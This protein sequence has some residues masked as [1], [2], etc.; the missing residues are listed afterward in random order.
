MEHLSDPA[1]P[2]IRR[3]V[4]N[5]P[6]PLIILD[7]CADER[8]PSTTSTGVS[9][10]GEGGSYLSG[11]GRGKANLEAED[12]VVGIGNALQQAYNACLQA[13]YDYR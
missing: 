8:K 6:D 9:D 12:E 10:N 3:F 5:F 2:S 7:G 13:L 11:E 4:D 1:C